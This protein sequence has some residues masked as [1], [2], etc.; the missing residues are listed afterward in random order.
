M[1]VI[2]GILKDSILIFLP[3]LQPPSFILI[4]PIISSVILGS[5]EYILDFHI[6]PSIMS[7]LYPSSLE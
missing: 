3:F 5:V 4:P 7:S 6:F 1:S 2:I